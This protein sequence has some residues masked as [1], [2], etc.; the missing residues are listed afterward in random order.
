MIWREGWADQRAS[1]QK[2]EEPL[3]NATLLA[4]SRD[5]EQ[6]SFSTRKTKV[7]PRDTFFWFNAQILQTA[8]TCLSATVQ[9]KSGWPW[10]Q[11]TW[12]TTFFSTVV[13]NK[14][15]GWEYRFL[16]K[17]NQEI[18]TLKLQVLSMQQRAFFNLTTINA[19]RTTCLIFLQA[20][21]IMPN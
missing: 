2:K 4:E 15:S 9:G 3:Q 17:R 12:T 18:N 11:P 21:G 20:P 5:P 16:M 6:I 1:Q 14:W 13:Q 7:A 8:I 10:Q 19:H